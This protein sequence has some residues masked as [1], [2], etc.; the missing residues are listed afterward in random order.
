M[1]ESSSSPKHNFGI[2]LPVGIPPALGMS[3][4]ARARHTKNGPYSYFDGPETEVIDRTL[5]AIVTDGKIIPG[6]RNGIRKV[7]VPPEGFYS[8]V[9]EVTEKTELVAVC[10]RR[11]DGEEPFIQVRAVSGQK[12]PATYVEIV[13]YRKDVLEEGGDP[14]T[15]AHWDI[16]S[17]NASVRENEPQ[18]PVSMAR[19]M[20]GLPGGT[21][22][23]YTAEQFAE[24]IIYWSTRAMKGGR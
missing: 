24:S 6:P 2:R 9:I 18:A 10:E 11:R 4:F 5:Y 13:I 16:V 14:T 15:G 3:E 20:L 21:K 17:I 1:S 8:G 12:I 19:N 23:V 7:V 22:A